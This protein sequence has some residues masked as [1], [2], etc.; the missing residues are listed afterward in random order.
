MT[1]GSSFR[2]LV[3]GRFVIGL[4]VSLHRGLED[5]TEEG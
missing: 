1:F 3:M 5:R 2:V 4:C